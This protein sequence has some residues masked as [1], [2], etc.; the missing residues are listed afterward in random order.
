[1][2]KVLII[3]GSPSRF[4]IIVEGISVYLRDKGFKYKIDKISIADHSFEESISKIVNYLDDIKYVY[5]YI[6][7]DP[8][9]IEFANDAFVRDLHICTL[10]NNKEQ[11]YVNFENKSVTA[12]TEFMKNIP[13]KLPMYNDFFGKLFYR[14]IS[15]KSNVYIETYGKINDSTIFLFNSNDKLPNSN[16]ITSINKLVAE[17]KRFSKTNPIHA[18]LGNK[19]NTS[20]YKTLETLGV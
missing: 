14:Q 11:A 7:L 9:F 13:N 10:E 6:F 17:H 20:L 19:R 1:M 12:K 8:S 3:N 4:P 15:R 2:K 18:F 5:D 16:A